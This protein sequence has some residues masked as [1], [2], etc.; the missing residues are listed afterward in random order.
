M[1]EP[2]T[3]SERYDYAFNFLLPHEGKFSNNKNDPGG[4]T[5]YGVSL[6]FLRAVGIDING[7]G[8]IDIKDILAIDKSKAKEI[9]KEWWW[10]KYYYEAINDIKVAAKIFDMAV[11]MGAKQAHKLVQ[12]SLNRLGCDC[13]VDGILGPKSLVA[14][15]NV[16]NHFGSHQLYNEI[17]DNCAHFYVNLAA[18]KPELKMFLKG[19]LRRANQ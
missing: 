5:M 16:C 4:A 18:D 6:R 10:D 2:L 14:I 13:D 19:W 11:N 9:Y 15:N 1:S 7:D 3:P 17:K 12:V 8:D